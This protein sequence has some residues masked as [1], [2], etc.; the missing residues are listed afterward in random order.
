MQTQAQ[1]FSEAMPTEDAMASTLA[2]K[3]LLLIQPASVAALSE[4][5]VQVQALLAGP[6][7]HSL[8]TLLEL[9]SL[10]LVCLGFSHR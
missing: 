3:T 9:P 2:L 5:V 6:V 7:P 4:R 1:L 8:P 10:F